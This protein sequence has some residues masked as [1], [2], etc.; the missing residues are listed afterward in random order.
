MNRHGQVVNNKPDA[1]LYL[2][3]STEEQVDNFSL[4]TQEEICRK[5]AMRQGMKI[6]KVFREEG[7]SAKTIT[8]KL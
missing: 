8:G 6:V 5:E 4:S 2:R 7:K 3:V 1:I